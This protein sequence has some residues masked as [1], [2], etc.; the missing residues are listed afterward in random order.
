MGRFVQQYR[1][2]WVYNYGHDI[3]LLLFYGGVIWSLINTINLL[4]NAKNYKKN[5]GWILLSAIPILYI[6]VMIIKTSFID[7]N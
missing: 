7:I 3:S 5:I 2:T 6:I 4:K 1:G